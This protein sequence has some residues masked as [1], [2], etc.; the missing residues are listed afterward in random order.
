VGDEFL[1]KILSERDTLKVWRQNHEHELHTAAEIESQLK[2]MSGRV[3]SENAA[4]YFRYIANAIT[5]T[6]KREAI[7][8]A[9]AK[10]EEMLASDG[11]IV[12]LGRRFV[13]AR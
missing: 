1:N 10:Q 6:E 5:E 11:S 8:Q 3:I 12:T 9:F 2:K 13:A 7:V 4:Y